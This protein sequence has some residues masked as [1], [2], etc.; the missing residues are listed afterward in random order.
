ME[1]NKIDSQC[2]EIQ[3]MGFSVRITASSYFLTATKQAATLN[4]LQLAEVEMFVKDYREKTLYPAGTQFKVRDDI[5]PY[6]LSQTAESTFAL[7]GLT[8]GN[9]WANPQSIKATAYLGLTLDQV[10]QLGPVV[11]VLDKGHNKWVKI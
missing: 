5:N 9:R 10:K 3:D 2:Y 6:I 11:E 7:I 1:F 8:S 4:S